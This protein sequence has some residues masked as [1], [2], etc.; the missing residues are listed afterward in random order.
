MVDSFEGVNDHFTS[1]EVLGTHSHN[2]L[3]RAKRYGRWYLLK[4][5]GDE[6]AGQQAYHEMLAKEFDIMMRLQHPGVA[7]AVSFEDVPG[8]G[9]CIVMEW[10]EG[11]TLAEWLKTSPS[12]DERRDVAH[13]LMA[14]L[15]HIHQH[16]V[17]HR[18]I[19]PSNVMVTTGGQQVKIIDFG[20][21]DTHIH[22]T[23]KQ[24]A[25]TARYMAPEQASEA[26]PDPRNDIY[27]LG[28][29]LKDMDL[30]SDY[31]S[32][33]KRCLMPINERFQTVDELIAAIDAGKKRRHRLQ[34]AAFAIG[35][36]LVVAGILLGLG[37]YGRQ[38]LE[39]P[40]GNYQFSDGVFV[41]T[42]WDGAQTNAVS[43]QY[44]GK[45]E[46]HVFL[47]QYAINKGV[48]WGVG[49]LGFGCFR[50]A[51]KM[52]HLTI[53][54]CNFGIQKHSFKGCTNLKSISMPNINM[55][56]PIGNGGW[57]TVIDSVF[58]PYHFE[59][60]TIYVPIVEEM[61]ADSS[62]SRFKHIEPYG[63]EGKNP[64]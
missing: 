13:Q 35:L 20:L 29:I 53:E 15:A 40:S 31:A 64:N 56:P 49:E 39:N 63:P 30:G 11:V 33:V 19:K 4:G 58:E 43:A 3:A 16:G 9:K 38:K 21:A 36:S 24:P 37:Y 7:Q 23:L 52:E 54:L 44:I 27:S 8:M 18:D 41:Y 45:G 57:Q 14:A 17:V 32:V 62:W 6:E 48:K 22:A 59:R 55:P 10:V 47:K 28:V 12:R 50:D 51:T 5:L 42:N 46:S 2:R 34:I 1:L 25:G 60:V 26:A 61:K